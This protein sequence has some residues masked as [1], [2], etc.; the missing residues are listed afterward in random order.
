[1]MSPGRE[2]DVVS[3]IYTQT[4]ASDYEKLCSTDNMGVEK[5]HQCKGKPIYE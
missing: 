5:S 4:S 1:M 3:A 2:S